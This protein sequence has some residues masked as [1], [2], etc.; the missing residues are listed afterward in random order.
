MGCISSKDID[1]GTTGTPILV[2][3]SLPASSLQE[4]LANCTYENT[5]PYNPTFSEGKCV[6]V[7]DGDTLHI[8]AE[9]E[10]KPYRFIIRMYGYDSPELR[11]KNPDEK[12]AGYA[13]KS[14]LEQRVLGKMVYVHIHPT[15]EKYGRVLA[16]LSDKE[17]EINQWMIDS[18]HGFPYFGG[19]KEKSFEDRAIED[20][21]IV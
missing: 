17:G 16:T 3:S 9:V 6:K 14:F 4:R 13:A 21:E 2:P 1:N 8:V 19:T 11:T 10:G 20:R 12:K 5:S 15:R 7:Y 18:K